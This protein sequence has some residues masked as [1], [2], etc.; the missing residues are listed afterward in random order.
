MLNVVD[1]I[2][3]TLRTLDSSEQEKAVQILHAWLNGSHELERAD[4]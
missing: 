2:V 4:A 1:D 3:A